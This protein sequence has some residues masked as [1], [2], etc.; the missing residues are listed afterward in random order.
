METRA[1]YV[2]VGAFVLVLMLGLAGFVIWLSQVTLQEETR[3]Y[4]ILFSGSVTGLQ[5]GST[6]RYRGIP[7]GEVTDISIPADNIE[8]VEVIVDVEA[9]APIKTDSF[10]RLEFQGITGG[11]YVLI[12][13]GSQDAPLLV[14]ASEEDPPRI[15]S[16]PSTIQA[17]L[18]SLPEIL[19]KTD[20]LMVQANVLLSEENV[21]A[22]SG[23][24][25]DVK[26]ITGALALQAPSLERVVDDI[27]SLV[28]NLD[29]LVEET[30]I[31]AARISDQLSGLIAKLD[32][33]TGSATGELE[34]TAQD[35]RELADSY[36]E[37]GNEV[38]GLIA[39]IR[40]ELEQFAGSGLTEFTLMVTE[41]RGLAETLSRVAE[42]IERAPARFLFGETGRGVPTE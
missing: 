42:Q 14:A 3:Q 30:R 31:D 18:D 37:L 5:V 38:S 12:A 13:G 22:L 17:V 15:E 39:D 21:A 16:E 36:T 34:A 35:L 33:T 7:I 9:E 40:P 8:Q 27:D 29:G 32:R 1:N 41:L 24:I 23:A 6:V 20:Q 11:V 2:A 26:T 28:V 19:A 4:R 25:D 10:A